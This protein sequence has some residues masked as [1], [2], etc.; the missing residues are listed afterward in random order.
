M[1]LWFWSVLSIFIINSVFLDDCNFE[2]GIDSLGNDNENVE[3]K[4]N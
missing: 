4:E 1:F 3:S 2:K